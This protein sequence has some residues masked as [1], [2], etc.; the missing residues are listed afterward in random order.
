MVC[1]VTQG[2]VIALVAERHLILRLQPTHL[3][4]LRNS[5]GCQE[6]V[7]SH[8]MSMTM[9]SASNFVVNAVQHFVVFLKTP[10]MVSLWVALMATQKLNWAGTSM[11]ARKQVGKLF[12]RVFLNTNRV[13]PTMINNVI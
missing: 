13:F 1:Y 2:H 6:K 7:F 8:P 9:A 3:L 4:S 11:S 12:Q 10:F 5:N